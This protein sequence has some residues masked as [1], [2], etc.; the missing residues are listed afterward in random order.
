MYST[1]LILWRREVIT[2]NFGSVSQG[3]EGGVCPLM[4]IDP[5]LMQYWFNTDPTPIQ[6]WSKIDPTPTQQR[7]SLKYNW[8]EGFAQYFKESCS[9]VHALR[10]YLFIESWDC[11]PM[12]LAVYALLFISVHVYWYW[13]TFVTATS[14]PFILSKIK[15]HYF[16]SESECS[17]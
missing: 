13:L 17:R 15:A 3:E 11:K 10:A 7:P 9:R 5:T 14:K 2:S 6:H 12:Y 16:E 4:Q 1:L 8:S